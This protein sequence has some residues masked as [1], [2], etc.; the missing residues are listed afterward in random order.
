MNYS[1]LQINIKNK[2]VN[3]LTNTRRNVR[4]FKC[5][6]TVIRDSEI[7]GKEDIASEKTDLILNRENLKVVNYEICNSDNDLKYT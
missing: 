2:E 7:G 4:N 3:K 5:Y 6:N 1:I